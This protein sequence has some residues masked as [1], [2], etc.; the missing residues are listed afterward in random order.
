MIKRI[1]SLTLILLHIATFG[2]MREA[3]AF[4]SSGT[5]Y[6]LNAD[7]TGGGSAGRTA[8]DAQS[9]VAF[10]AIG[11]PCVGEATSTSY[12]LNAGFIPVIQSN[13]PAMK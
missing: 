8:I 2:P 6:N 9:M 1:L 5:S 11:E 10:D 13:P 12:V 3:A 4:F 7:V